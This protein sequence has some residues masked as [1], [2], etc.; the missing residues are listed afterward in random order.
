M[1][2]PLYEG[3]PLPKEAHHDVGSNGNGN[4]VGDAGFC[5]IPAVISMPVTKTD[6]I[7]KPLNEEKIPDPKNPRAWLR[8]YFET[9]EGR[10]HVLTRLRSSDSIFIHC[11]DRAFG[12]V[13]DVMDVTHRSALAHKSEDE[14]RAIVNSP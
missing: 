11:L 3:V 1:D 2:T 13:K 4:G 8:Q 9:A 12:K 5:E 6:M 7:H 10:A 14:L